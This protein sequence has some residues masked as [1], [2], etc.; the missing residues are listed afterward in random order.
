[1]GPV[2]CS[3][4]RDHQ[5]IPEPCIPHGTSIRRENSV[6][7]PGAEHGTAPAW[8]LRAEANRTVDPVPA[9]DD[10]H[11]SRVAI[12][13][14]LR[15]RSLVVLWGRATERAAGHLSAATGCAERTIRRSP[16]VTTT[17]PTRLPQAWHCDH[18]DRRR[19]TIARRRLRS[20]QDPRRGDRVRHGAIVP[21]AR[22][23]LLLGEGMRPACRPGTDAFVAIYERRGAGRKR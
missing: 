5:Q 18:A 9:L 16:A 13:G 15:S 3:S 22:L 8:P 6:P 14:T 20:P 17:Q 10:K 7:P 1:M 19:R 12:G 21:A 2:A 11:L 4:L 23:L